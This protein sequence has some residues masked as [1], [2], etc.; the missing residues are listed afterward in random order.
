MD[1]QQFKNEMDK[2]DAIIE[3]QTKLMGM[4][5]MATQVKEK[6]NHL[7]PIYHAHLC[8]VLDDIWKAEMMN[9]EAIEQLNG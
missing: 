1:Y 2:K 9:V 7:P 4:L 8:S 6:M 3:A 5:E